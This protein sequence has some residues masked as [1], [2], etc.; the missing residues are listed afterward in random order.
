MVVALCR[1]PTLQCARR[2]HSH[3]IH[4]LNAVGRGTL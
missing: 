3:D 4:C 1:K 2:S